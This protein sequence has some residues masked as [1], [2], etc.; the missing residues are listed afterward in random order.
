MN[1]T[2]TAAIILAAGGSKRMGQPKQLIK[3]QG[4]T[5]L[6]HIIEKTSQAHLSPII[7]VL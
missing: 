2:Q 5:F 7:I 3:W 1:K 6:D 4:K